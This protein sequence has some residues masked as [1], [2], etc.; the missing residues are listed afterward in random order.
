MDSVPIESADVPVCEEP[1]LASRRKEL[2]VAP[3]QDRSGD[4][5]AMSF[6]EFA[7]VAA[8]DVSY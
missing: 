7:V 5:A 8:E 4:L 6:E 3:V 2:P 1:T